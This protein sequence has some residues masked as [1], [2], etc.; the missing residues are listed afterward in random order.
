MSDWSDE[1]AL[2]TAEA[3]RMQAAEAQAEARFD[4]VFARSE[5][6][7]APERAPASEEFHLWMA[8]RRATD[9]AWGTWSLVMDSKPA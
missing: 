7:G 4:T 8:A 1:I 5:A 9:A 6:D 3:E 2:A